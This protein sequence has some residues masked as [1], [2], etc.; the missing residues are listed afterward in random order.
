[1]P[2]SYFSAL[3]GGDWEEVRPPDGAVFLDRDGEVSKLL[4]ELHALAGGHAGDMRSQCCM[5][6]FKHILQFLRA[7]R[8]SK[9]FI[10]PAS[11]SQDTAAAVA[12][13]AVFLGRPDLHTA[14]MRR[15]GEYE[16][17][18]RYYREYSEIRDCLY[19]KHSPVVVEPGWELVSALLGFTGGGIYNTL[20]VIC[21]RLKPSVQ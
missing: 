13:K 21:R 11:V 18:F 10:L 6:V 19:K 2:D 12:D 1:M 16:Y 4:K 9:P 7:N 3:F 5:Q 8:D 15:T 17:D 14:S 20:L